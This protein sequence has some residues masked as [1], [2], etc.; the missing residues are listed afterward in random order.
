MERVDVDEL[1]KVQLP[2]QPVATSETVLEEFVERELTS[3]HGKKYLHGVSHGPLPIIMGITGHR[4]LREQDIPKLEELLRQEYR[5]IQQRYSS[6][7]FILLSA[8]AD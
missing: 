7:S 6:T 1:R 5:H 3:R 4:D 2:Q 8:L